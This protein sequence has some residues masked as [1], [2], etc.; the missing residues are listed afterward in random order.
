[1]KAKKK[2]KKHP[3]SRTPKSPERRSIENRDINSDEQRIITNA[4]VLG[5]GSHRVSD[6][7]E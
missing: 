2:K 4:P 5:G 1:M 7:Q 3:V 6:E